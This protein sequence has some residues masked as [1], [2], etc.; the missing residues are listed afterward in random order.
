M[1]SNK[2]QIFN[3]RCIPRKKKKKNKISPIR[4]NPTRAFVSF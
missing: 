1:E 3:Q 4:H 2:Q